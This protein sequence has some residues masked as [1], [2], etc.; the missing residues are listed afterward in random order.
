MGRGQGRSTCV[1]LA[2]IE[3]PHHYGTVWPAL[4]SVDNEHEKKAL[5][6]WEDITIQDITS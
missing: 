3:G 1:P 2:S 4:E 6:Q 5:Y